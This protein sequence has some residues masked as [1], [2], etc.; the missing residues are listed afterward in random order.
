MKYDR[1]MA[2]LA[3]E[4]L[5]ITPAA[6]GALARLFAEHR[7]LSRADF[8]M[9][10]E[11]TGACGAVVEL[12]QMEIIDGVAHIPIGGPI[13]R[14]LGKFEKWAGAVDVED[15]IGEIDEAEES[16]EGGAILLDI[17][18]PG[19]MYSGTPELGDRILQ[20]Q[21]PIYAF[22]AGMMCSAAYWAAA[23]T[24]GIFTTRTATVGSIGVYC[25][26]LDSSAAMEKEGLKVDVFTSGRYKGAGI[27]GTT[28]SED[29]RKMLQARVEEMAGA[30]YQHVEASRPDVERTDMQG[31]VFMGDRAVAAG[32]VDQVVRDKGE[33]VELIGGSGAGS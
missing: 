24:D 18:S 7:S 25:A 17:D 13:G 23:A 3:E 31:Q 29:H 28:L 15:V 16:A 1:I 4:P 19:G 21:K 30:F 20:C 6:H 9:K 32:L 10:R 12:E 33:A 8:E 14:G 11:G 5:L 26:Y 27:P 22:S 2:L